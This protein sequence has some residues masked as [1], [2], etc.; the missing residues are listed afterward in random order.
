MPNK[1]YLKG[2]RK[3]YAIM[4]KYKALG[5]ICLRTAGSHG[6]ADIIAIHREQEEILFIQAKSGDFPEYKL[7][8]LY[9]DY[10]WLT[11]TFDCR[12]VVE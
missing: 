7:K 2:R 12:F 9:N 8:N 4:K 11:K 5:Y 6:F 1:N 3:E 10:R